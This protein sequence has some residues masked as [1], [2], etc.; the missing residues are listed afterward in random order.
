[1]NDTSATDMDSARSLA[2]IKGVLEAA[3][4]VAGEPVP[5]AQLS[6][7]FEP[8]LEAETVRKLLDELKSDWSGRKVELAQVA[9][10]WRFQ[11]R[12]EVQRYLD[13]L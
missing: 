9:S 2:Q 13:R 1:M 8:P 12:A 7:L 5:S 3:L 6:K 11:G 10:G 4:L